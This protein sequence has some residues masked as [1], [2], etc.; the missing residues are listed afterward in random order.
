MK[1]V[2]AQKGPGCLPGCPVRALLGS[3][4]PR[5]DC[6]VSEHEPRSYGVQPLRPED[7]VG[8]DSAVK[9]ET[10]QGPDRHKRRL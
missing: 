9:Y 5:S 3:M 10:C 4:T 1:I 6:P 2:N 8:Q 7:R